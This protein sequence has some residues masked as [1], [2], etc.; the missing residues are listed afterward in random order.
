MSSEEILKNFVKIEEYNKVAKSE[1]YMRK[2]LTC[3]SC[4]KL[5]E[6][7]K[8]NQTKCKHIYCDSCMNKIF[9]SEGEEKKCSI[10]KTPIEKG[11]IFKIYLDQ[12]AI[13]EK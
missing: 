5:P 10:C 7:P 3:Q 9:K 12:S 4:G 13:N 8:Y 1:A 2:I 6:K 11:S